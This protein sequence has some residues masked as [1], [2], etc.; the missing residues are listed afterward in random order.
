MM[1]HRPQRNWGCRIHDTQ[2]A[3]IRTIVLENETIRI[4]FLAGKGTD[5]VEFNY[6]PR[7]L[8]FAWLAPGS[9]RNP[10][11]MHS[12]SPDPLATF[13][14]SYP[15]GW[16]EVFPNAGAPSIHAGAHYGQHGEVF[17]LPWDVEII[18]DAE[19]SVAVRFSVR[20]QKIP[21]RI[22]KTIRLTG[23]EPLLE[24]HETLINESPVSIDA[25]WGHHITFGKPF[26]KPGHRITLP[27]SVIAQPHDVDVGPSGRR[28]ASDDAF[29]WPLGT[30]ADDT[31]VD[32]S[33]IPDPGTPSELFYISGFPGGIGWYEIVDP[34]PNLGMRV[35]WDAGTMPYLWYWQEFGATTGYPWYGRTYN[36]G[37]EPSSS[38]PT[39]GLPD[40]VANGSALMLGPGETR[41]FWL[42]A[43]VVAPTVPDTPPQRLD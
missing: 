19:Q 13:L 36:V 11:S 7:D 30:G 23:S 39:N 4:S 35:E 18:D 16:Q 43:Q 31:P 17:A 32:F 14:D 20:G 9:I 15:G 6:K 29:A 33:V 25:M 5:L 12:T 37:L 38:Y 26:L 27:D 42:R 8:D 28:V 22:T 24:I 34:S 10:A 2:L 3:G 21:G 41:E 1:L 40:A